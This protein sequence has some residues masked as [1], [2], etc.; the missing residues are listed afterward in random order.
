MLRISV[1]TIGWRDPDRHPHLREAAEYHLAA[2]A[3]ETRPGE[4]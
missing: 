1:A 4:G 3:A 2:L